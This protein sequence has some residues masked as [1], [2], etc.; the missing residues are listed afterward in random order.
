MRIRT[1]NYNHL[2]SQ[3]DPYRPSIKNS[4]PGRSMSFP[5]SDL[6]I[7]PNGDD[8]YLTYGD[9]SWINTFA[10]PTNYLRECGNLLGSDPPICN[11]NT[12]LDMPLFMTTNTITIDLRHTTMRTQ[13]KVSL[14]EIRSP[15]LSSTSSSTLSRAGSDSDDSPSYKPSKPS[16]CTK[17]SKIRHDRTAHSTVEKHYRDG[18]NAALRRLQRAIPRFAYSEVK[19]EGGA[20]T[21]LGPRAPKK[22][23]VLNAAVEYIQQ[24]EGERDT[25]ADNYKQLR[26]AGFKFL[27]GKRC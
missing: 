23:A 24:L 11:I 15:S 12:P 2:Q 7:D 18:V 26:N 21:M 5:V 10:L 8:L 14:G 22:T 13:D 20:D 3:S 25:L 4:T 9:N 19:I 1:V 17:Q 16:R 6:T 27:A